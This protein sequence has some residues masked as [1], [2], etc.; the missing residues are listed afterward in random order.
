M[1][2]RQLGKS[3]LRVAPLCLGG[4]VFGWT[5]D[6][7]T[8]FAVLDA[9]VEGG[10]NFIDTADVYARWA[11]GNS[12]GESEA[13]LGRWLAAR[14]NR[15]DVIIATKV[16][17]PM[18]DRPN[19]SGL[20]RAHII[21]GVEASLR[22]LG[23]DYID[24]Y[25]AHQDDPT[26]PIEESLAAFD[27]LVRAGKVRYLGASNFSAWRLMQSLGVSDRR[28]YAP[29]VSLQPAYNLMNR[30]IENDIVPMCQQEGIGI[31]PYSSLASGFLTGKY[32]AGQEL[33]TSARAGGVQGRY[34]NARGER[35]LATLDHLT[36][37]YGATL[38]QLALAW[39]LAKP[40]VTAP[41]ASGTSPVQVRELL[42]ALAVQLSAADVA[43]LDAASEVG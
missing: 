11:P 17:S 32:R 37:G 33:P 12:G 16:G 34:M 31:I 15:A 42:G 7:P 27:A 23:T 21:A 1:E 20:S 36:E 41:I 19:D 3:G 24:L 38:A 25:Q 18:S 43:A 28:G 6:E 14:A 10:G 22:R 5:I 35:V 8:S 2:M 39:L 26:T 13:V 30:A 40:T 9:Y 4:N 29:Y